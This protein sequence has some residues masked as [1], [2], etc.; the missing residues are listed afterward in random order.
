MLS[1]E[2]IPSGHELPSYF[3]RDDDRGT[4]RGIRDTDSIGASYDRYLRSAV[5]NNYLYCFLYLR[6]NFCHSQFNCI[7]RSNGKMQYFSKFLLMVVDNLLDHLVGDYRVMLSMIRELWV[8][9]V[10]NKVLL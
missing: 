5:R 8:L 7:L 1:F 2:D 6:Y 3:S 10:W 4:L 9:G